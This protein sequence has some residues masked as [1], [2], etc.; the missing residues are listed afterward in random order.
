[1]IFLVEIKRPGF[2]ADRVGFVVDKVALGRIFS[3][4]FGFPCQSSFHQI[5]HHHNHP[6]Q[7]TIG[8][9]MAAVASG[10]SLCSAVIENMWRYT[11]IPPFICTS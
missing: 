1:M 8:Q 5:L 9:S 7:A 6:V 10:P 4:Y 2:G 3:E 11:S